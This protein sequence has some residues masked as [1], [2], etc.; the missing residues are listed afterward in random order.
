M[1]IYSPRAVL[2]PRDLPGS[3]LFNCGK[4]TMS[5]GASFDEY[6]G[7]CRTCRLYSWSKVWGF[8]DLCDWTVSCRILI[9]LEARVRADYFLKTVY[10]ID[11]ILSVQ[12][13]IWCLVVFA[14]NCA[15]IS[16]VLK[17]NVYIA[18]LI[19]LFTQINPLVLNLSAARTC[20][21]AFCSAYRSRS[22]FY[23]PL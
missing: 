10:I 13:T 5:K 2:L 23:H 21:V 9:L 15:T 3:S 17:K 22:R 4:R 11:D 20:F 16:F 18:L 19:D 12:A 14:G 6:G 1:N 7:H 8:A